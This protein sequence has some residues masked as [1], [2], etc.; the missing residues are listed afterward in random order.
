MPPIIMI[1]GLLFVALFVLVTVLEKYGK[2]RSDEELSQISRFIFPLVGI[3]L[4]AQLL[5]MLFR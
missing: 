4:L 3:V 5:Y 1:L 2:K